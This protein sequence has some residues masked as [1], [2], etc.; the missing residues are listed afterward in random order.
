MARPLP[1]SWFCAHRAA[2]GQTGMSPVCRPWT[3]P[4]ESARLSYADRG[5]CGIK[6]PLP[7]TPFMVGSGG[8]WIVKRLVVVDRL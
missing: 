6:E 3:E 7:T 2:P 1:T 8:G 4:L 5:S